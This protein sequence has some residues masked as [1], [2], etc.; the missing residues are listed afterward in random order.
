MRVADR[1][2]QQWRAGVARPWVPRGGRVLDVGCFQGEFLE[3]LGDRIAPSVGLD[4]LV[5]PPETPGRHE[6]MARWFEPPLA[7]EPGSFDA[8]V[9]LATLEHIR[10]KDPLAVE[11]RRLLRPGG[12]VIV[13]VPSGRVDAIVDVL[14]RLGLADGMSLDEHHGFDPTRTPEVFARHGFEVEYAGRFQL[15]LNHLFVLRAPETPG[16]SV[17]PRSR[18]ASARASVGS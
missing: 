4:P 18:A 11:C 8:V 12:R 5:V 16:A 10:D 2:L 3:S 17:G 6:L 7:F 9:M 13:T 14:C 15:G 1:L